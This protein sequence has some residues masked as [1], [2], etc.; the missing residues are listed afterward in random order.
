M[1]TSRSCSE[2]ALASSLASFIGIGG[3]VIALEALGRISAPAP[4]SSHACVLKCCC[5]GVF[6]MA[7]KPTLEGPQVHE[8]P[9]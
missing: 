7:G 4:V 6:C 9:F 2:L 5:E 8:G 1:D 3:R